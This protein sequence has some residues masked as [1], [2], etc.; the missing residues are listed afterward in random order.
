MKYG[1]LLI[2]ARRLSNPTWQDSWLDY[3]ALKGIIYTIK[4]KKNNINKLESSDDDESTCTIN[5]TETAKSNSDTH[6]LTTT[7]AS[8]SSSSSSSATG[9]T[10]QNILSS[11][12]NTSNGHS[13]NNNKDA[14]DATN[15]TTTTTTKLTAQQQNTLLSRTFFEKLRLELRKVSLF[16]NEQ[17]KKLLSRTSNFAE[18]LSAAESQIIDETDIEE[19][20]ARV[21]TL[22]RLMESVSGV[23]DHGQSSILLN[24]V[25][26][27]V[28]FFCMG[29]RLDILVCC[30]FNIVFFVLI[31]F[32]IFFSFFFFFLLL[33][34]NTKQ[35]KVLYVD[36][37][38]LENFA[39]MNYGGFAKILKKHDK[40]TEF[41]TQERYLRKVV[42]VS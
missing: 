34:H 17:E 20:E 29:F 31:F 18:E 4:D 33:V 25:F 24:Y 38:M 15:E 8:A 36:L 41:I 14:V 37:M 39:V 42:N 26:F 3:H 7:V 22:S 1:R 27:Y 10:T 13:L 5:T 11:H 9:T 19:K 23:F 6:S 40:N 28:V 21:I 35:C 32:F 16:F 12:R 30:C 2:R